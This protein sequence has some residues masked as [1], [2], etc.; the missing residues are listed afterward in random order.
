[1]AVEICVM[2]HVGPN[3]FVDTK[4]FLAIKFMT[5]VHK[6]WNAK[7][8]M[9]MSYAATRLMYGRVKFLAQFVRFWAMRNLNENVNISM[10]SGFH[11][12]DLQ[13][14]RLFCN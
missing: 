12:R 7:S 1:M 13:N 14:E 2:I 11:R 3:E 10:L 4:A 9:L 6:T 5:S 8:V